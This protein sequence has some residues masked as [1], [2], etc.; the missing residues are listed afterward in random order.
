MS[1]VTIICLVIIG[2]CLF[3]QIGFLFYTL[4]TFYKCNKEI[5]EAR[6]QFDDTFKKNK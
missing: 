1:I 3:I 5:K 4:Y 2:I 6:K